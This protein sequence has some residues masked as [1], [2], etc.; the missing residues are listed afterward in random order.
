M[1]FV[2]KVDIKIKYLDVY[3]IC[4]FFLY[5][6]KIWSSFQALKHRCLWLSDTHKVIPFGLQLLFQKAGEYLGGLL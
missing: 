4:E 6:V 5:L 1:I 3:I 2:S